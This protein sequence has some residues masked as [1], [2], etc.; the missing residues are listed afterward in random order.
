MTITGRL[1]PVDDGQ[2]RPASTP[3]GPAVDEVRDAQ[4]QHEA[5]EEREQTELRPPPTVGYWSG[6][7]HHVDDADEGLLGSV[8]RMLPVAQLLAHQRLGFRHDPLGL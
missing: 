7:R 2:D 5:E 1:R 6:R 3:P 4:A 8:E